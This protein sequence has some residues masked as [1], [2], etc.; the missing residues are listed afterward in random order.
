MITIPKPK[1]FIRSLK[2][3]IDRSFVYSNNYWSSKINEQ[4]DNVMEVVSEFT[5]QANIAFN[6]A[7]EQGAKEAISMLYAIDLEAQKLAKHSEGIDE[8]FRLSDYWIRT[9]FVHKNYH[10]KLNDPEVL[11]ASIVAL[12]S[13]FNQIGWDYKQASEAEHNQITTCIKTYYYFIPPELAEELKGATIEQIKE[14][15]TVHEMALVLEPTS[16]FPECSEYEDKKGKVW[17]V[18]YYTDKSIMCEPRDE[19]HKDGSFKA[20]PFST[21]QLL[22]MKRIL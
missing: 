4:R 15:V 6:K 12:K 19:A 2:P 14:K 10:D 3:Y 16:R 7:T 13:I 11:E 8:N 20:V 21:R 9:M 5:K 18:C 17:K 22:M 1:Q